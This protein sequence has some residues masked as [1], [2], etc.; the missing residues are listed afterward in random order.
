MNIDPNKMFPRR[1]ALNAGSKV[2][3]VVPKTID[4][5]K[6]PLSSL[7]I[8]KKLFIP[9]SN[10]A[11]NN[12][13]ELVDELLELFNR[14][15]DKK[16]I[17]ERVIKHIAYSTL[18]QYID[19]DGDHGS[20]KNDL[21][22][23]SNN[24]NFQLDEPMRS[25]IENW[26]T[27][28]IPVIQNAVGST[29]TSILKHS[30]SVSTYQSSVH[31]P[32]TTYPFT[33]KYKKKMSKSQIVNIPVDESSTIE[34]EEQQDLASVE[35]FDIK[36]LGTHHRNT[37]VNMIENRR[38]SRADVTSVRNKRTRMTKKRSEMRANPEIVEEPI[39]G[40]FSVK[41]LYFACK[42][43]VVDHP[44][45]YHIRE[46]ERA[47]I[48]NCQIYQNDKTIGMPKKIKKLAPV[49]NETH[50]FQDINIIDGVKFSRQNKLPELAASISNQQLI[51]MK[52]YHPNVLFMQDKMKLNERKAS[53]H[54]S[55][56]Y[57]SK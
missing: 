15:I 35:F 21:D 39:T 28:H 48:K 1:S 55:I 24:I 3:F 2:S 29:F 31:D 26:A 51:L 49:V 56:L 16:N 22:I 40:T 11:H 30:P 18:Q 10:A 57:T 52:P 44:S 9:I 34:S 4:Q 17:T 54:S 53:K 33:E 47:P 7:P 36:S 41:K 23:F 12:V 38:P 19:N 45:S 37:S 14:E 27:G 32:H 20:E 5:I 25:R 46:R 8:G 13:I 43:E 50:F 42:S 6:E